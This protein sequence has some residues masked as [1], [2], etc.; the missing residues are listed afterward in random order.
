MCADISSIAGTVPGRSFSIL[1]QVE[2]IIAS[3]ER[4][5]ATPEIGSSGVVYIGAFP[6]SLASSKVTKIEQAQA[7]L[8]QGKG[9]NEL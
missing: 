7:V 3:N 5:S 4:L 9:I 8:L 6:L 1:R 2:A